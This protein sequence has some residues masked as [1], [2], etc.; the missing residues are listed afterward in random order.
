LFLPGGIEIV[1]DNLFFSFHVP[2]FVPGLWKFP[3][4]MV[5]LMTDLSSDD[6]LSAILLRP[7]EPPIV[8]IEDNNAKEEEDLEV[9]EEHI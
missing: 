9:E 6:N 3:L 5:S 7:V 2:L 8:D 4:V 1:F